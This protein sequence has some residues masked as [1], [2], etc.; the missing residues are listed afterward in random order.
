MCSSA[1]ESTAGCTSSFQEEHLKLF[2]NRES[3]STHLSLPIQDSP[4]CWLRSWPLEGVVVSALSSGKENYVLAVLCIFSG[5]LPTLL[6][7]F[8]SESEDQLAAVFLA[9]GGFH[10]A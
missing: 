6:Y 1:D 10:L 7:L 4:T 3:A 8:I 9:F 5:G 2:S